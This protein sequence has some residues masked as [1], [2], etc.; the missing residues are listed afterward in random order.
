M[1]VWF[2][3]DLHLGHRLV[4]SLRGFGDSRETADT[5]VHD[6]ALA[7]R[8]DAVVRD[9]DVVWVLG[10]LCIAKPTDALDWMMDRPGRKRLILGN[11]DSAHPMHSRAV[12]ATAQ[13]YDAF[14]W[15]GTFA[16]I[17]LMGT[18][19]LLSHF[20]YPGEGADRPDYA[21]ARY[22]QYR[23][24]NE[25]MWLIHGH[26]HTSVRLHHG[27]QIHVGLDAWD[28]TPVADHQIHDLMEEAECSCGESDVYDGW[29]ECS[30]H[31]QESP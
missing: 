31:P 30:V 26:L 27:N 17:K 21:E 2:T 8:W 3:S 11:H 1:T 6:A 15:V 20:P 28:L 18:P 7:A 24:P 5:R 23:L 25:G 10:D 29:A 14:D 22:T 12:K 4:A 16:R 19:V 9:D 13:F